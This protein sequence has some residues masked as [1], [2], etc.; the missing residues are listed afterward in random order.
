M[1][2][3]ILRRDRFFTVV[4]GFD[5]IR[6]EHTD[7]SFLIDTLSITELL[8]HFLELEDLAYFVLR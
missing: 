3:L 6:V 2:Q 5:E 4:L 8:N 1:W 7:H